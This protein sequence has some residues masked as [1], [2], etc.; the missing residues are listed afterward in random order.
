MR[1]HQIKTF[2]FLMKFSN[3]HCFHQNEKDPKVASCFSGGLFLMMIVH[4]FVVSSIC[5]DLCLHWVPIQS[6]PVEHRQ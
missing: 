3:H 6:G 5:L 4:S 1:I 2:I